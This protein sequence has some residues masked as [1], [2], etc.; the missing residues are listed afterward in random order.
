MTK[1]R[2]QSGKTLLQRGF[3]A[4]MQ[5]LAACGFI[6]GVGMMQS[7]EKDVL[8]GQPEWLGNSI[9]ERL[10]EGIEVNGEKKSFT[11]TLRLIDDL[12]Y[13]EVLAQTGSKTLFVASDEDYAAWFNNNTWG[14]KSYEEL[15]EF[16]KKQLFHSTMIND[17]YLVDL[18]S[19]VS[20]NPPKEGLC[21]RRESAVQIN[22]YVPRM[23]V[24]D[25]P[26]N[27][28]RTSD[29]VNLAWEK[30]RQ[31]GREN[32]T[33]YIY[34]DATPAPMIHFLPS[35]M[36]NNHIT[37]KDLQIIS[38]GASNSIADSWI[39]GK[40]IISDELTCKNG[41]IYVV[42]GVMELNKSMMDIIN[43]Q[44]DLTTWAR[45]LNRWA[46]PADVSYNQLKEFQRLYNTTDSVYNL[47]YLNKS[48]N[49]GY[50]TP[51]GNEADNINSEGLLLFDP[52]WNQYI[53]PDNHINMNYDAGVMIVP[54]NE[55]LAEWFRDKGQGSDLFKKFE[56]W[57]NIPLTTLAQLMNVNMQQ[58]FIAAVPSKFGTV[59]NDIQR[60]LGIKAED[61]VRCHMGCN[62]V[63]YVVNKVY[64]PAEFSSVVFPLNVEGEGTFSAIYHALTGSYYKDALLDDAFDVSRWDFRPYLKAMDSRFSV[65]LPYN[66]QTS[67]N[68][69]TQK[70]GQTVFRM[71]SPCT[72]GQDGVDNQVMIEFWYDAVKGD[73]DG[74]KYNCKVAADGTVSL[75]GAPTAR[76]TIVPVVGTKKSY[77]QA[78][79]ILYDYIDNCI[80]LDDI[81]PG[82]EYYK[83]KAGSIVRVFTEGGK[84]CIQGG[85]QMEHGTK[86][87]IEEEDK[88]PKKNGYTYGLNNDVDPSVIDLP[89][90]SQKSVYQILKEEKD[91]GG[92]HLFFDL[93]YGDVSGDNPV[94]GVSSV[95]FANK[96]GSYY[97]PQ[98]KKNYNISVFDNY[99]Y[100]VYIPSD[101]KIQ[102]MIDNG[103]LPQWQDYTNATTNEEKIFIAERI[104]DFLRYHIQDNSV[105]VKG[106]DIVDE[107]NPSKGQLFESSK[108]NPENKRFYSV[109]VRVKD[110]EMTVKDQIHSDARTI[111]IAS[112]FYNKP[113]R[114]AWISGS[115]PTAANPRTAVLTLASTSHAVLHRVSDVL[116]FDEDQEKDWKTVYPDWK[117]KYE[118]SKK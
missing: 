79:S 101:E 117:K 46:V 24:A 32:D 63:I 93:L 58:S 88:F 89:M 10:E 42:D 108:M 25:M 2:I 114:E 47:R 91:N 78:T 55:A 116:L 30:F 43:E 68:A 74:Y 33:I 85:F 82:Q 106:A 23:A 36:Q 112:G 118:S 51:T 38:N 61:V 28:L 104:H 37:D 94:V 49:Y 65:F 5:L 87:E 59:Y 109:E 45:N 52:A 35:F 31:P 41:Y 44:P 29:P 3:R 77:D 16:Q 26:Y 40:K 34:K 83:T 100:T 64:E 98:S 92:D 113:A 81:K 50:A 103:Y 75:V 20:G 102:A 62:G 105:C 54:T 84:L 11:T 99:N 21:M 22:D 12:G 4:S 76:T 56:E 60:P 86:V 107:A 18:M 96:Q 70:S 73:L 48:S 13:K 80:I 19:N 6:A 7:C 72:P 111:D 1:N 15:S 67:L 8:T 71:L 14:V 57:D 9:Y 17:A 39:N 110:G 115:E 95:L 53:S 27:G 69:T 66:K 97:C 90:P